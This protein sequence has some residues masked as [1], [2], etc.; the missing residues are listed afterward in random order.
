[1]YPF[2]LGLCRCRRWGRRFR[3]RLGLRPAARGRVRQVD[4]HV[5]RHFFEKVG[6]DQ[7]PVAVDLT[8][9]RGGQ[10]RRGGQP[11]KAEH[12]TSHIK[13]VQMRKRLPT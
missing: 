8:L 3:L 7:A 11:S 5:V 12:E 6:G 4:L 1:M 9:Q 13:H 2:G 10:N